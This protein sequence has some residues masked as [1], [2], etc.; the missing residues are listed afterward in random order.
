MFRGA[1]SSAITEKSGITV[2]GN[3]EQRNMVCPRNA[4]LRE[5]EKYG[6]CRSPQWAKR[7]KKP[8]V[9]GASPA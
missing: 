9:T 1:F 6:F 2:E 5:Q 3:V 7:V 8:G 4:Q